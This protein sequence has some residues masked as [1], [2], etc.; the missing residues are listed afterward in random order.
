MEKSRVQN[1]PKNKRFNFQAGFFSF[2]ICF[3]G[4]FPAPAQAQ[5][6]GLPWQE[7]RSQHFIVYYR[8]APPEFVE[9]LIH[10]AEFFYNSIVD[11]IGF[12]RFDFWSWDNRARIYLYRN[13]AEFQKATQN[14]SWARAVVFVN[15]RTIKT[16]V[17]QS[18]FF[19]SILPH[20]LTHIIFR[21]FIG[22]NT[23]LPL[24]IEE[25]VASSQ[26]KSYLNLRLDTARELVRQNKYL[27]LSRLSAMAR[28][29]K[30]ADSEVFY[31]ESASLFIFLIR[32]KG[33]EDFLDFSRLLRDGTDWEKALL[34][35][36][37]FTSLQDL[38]DGWR[39]FM[40]RQ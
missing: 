9:E 36:F 29:E 27:G 21:E 17:G 3:F 39:D 7:N 2:F 33:K 24:W 32:Q 10:R 14:S 13:A 37:G 5:T 25:G 12:R 28:P 23:S 4:F 11:E 15:D 34:K 18:G 31:S 20:E 6:T 1:K 38:E 40:L 16:Y 22:R 8:E 26:E 30:D 35:A 19:D